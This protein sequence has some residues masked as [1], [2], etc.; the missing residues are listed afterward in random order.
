MMERT[1]PADEQSCEWHASFTHSFCPFA[2]LLRFFFRGL[3][4]G[5]GVRGGADKSKLSLFLPASITF[6]CH[7]NGNGIQRNGIGWERKCGHVCECREKAER[8][9]DWADRVM[10]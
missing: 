3:G 7:S 1:G 8:G 5:S 10:M 4:L 6:A 2:C 9:I